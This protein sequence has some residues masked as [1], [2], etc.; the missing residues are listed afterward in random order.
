MPPSLLSG[1]DQLTS[2]LTAPKQ[3]PKVTPM[4]CCQKCE[5]K[6]DNTSDIRILQCSSCSKR[7][8]DACLSPP[9]NATL[10][11]K[12]IKLSSPHRQ[13]LCTECKVCY[14]CKSSSNKEGL[15]CCQ[16]CDIYA[17]QTC[18]QGAKMPVAGAGGSWKC[19]DCITCLS[20]QTILP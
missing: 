3:P 5:L 19:C 14:I 11:K 2:T 18:L 6:A 16:M 10:V 17:H 20:C 7:Y 13:W 12:A 4:N 9:K 8:H 1:H 15:L